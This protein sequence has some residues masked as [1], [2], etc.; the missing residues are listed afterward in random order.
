MARFYVIG[1]KVD[2]VAGGRLSA[3]ELAPIG[4]GGLAHSLPKAIYLSIYLSINLS[5]YQSIYLPI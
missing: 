1:P 2:S 5:I 4:T 3:E